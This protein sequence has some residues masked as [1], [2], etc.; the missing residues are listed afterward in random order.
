MFGTIILAVAIKLWPLGD[1]ITEGSNNSANYRIPLCQKLEQAGVRVETVGFRTLKN[2]DGKGGEIPKRWWAHTGISGQRAISGGGRAG[3]LDSLE[4]LVYQAGY[5]D[6]IVFKL[7]TNDILRGMDAE[8]AFKA[9]LKLVHRLVELR[10]N[11]KIVVCTILDMPGKTAIVDDYNAR[12]KSAVA[13][14]GEFPLNQVFL[15]DLNPVVNRERGD[16]LDALHP[17]WQG[18]DR[19]SDVLKD[20]ILAALKTPPLKAK[21]NVHRKRGAALNVEKAAIKGFHKVAEAELPESGIGFKPPVP[22][23]N[24]HVAYYL[25]L[26]RKDTDEICSVWC[27]MEKCTLKYDAGDGYGRFQVWEGNKLLF[28]FNRFLVDGVNELGIGAFEQHYLGNDKYSRDYTHTWAT[29]TMNAA[30]YDLRHLELWQ[31]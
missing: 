29:P 25:E 16:Y 20:V 15:A 6:V 13:K 24:A 28:A 27:D 10:P 14:K 18:H 17:N 11:A 9:W 2:V 19:T 21:A 7:G 1:S 22:K 26:K 31:R 8:T 3:Y 30:A 4:P 5:P 23:K 12:I